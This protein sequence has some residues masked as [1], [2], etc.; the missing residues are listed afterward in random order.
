MK[1][2]TDI[3][4]IKALGIALLTVFTLASCNSILGEEDADCS[5]EYRVKFKYDYNMKY[6]DAFAHEVKSVTLYAFDEN[7]KFVY[8][9]TEQGDIL[10][11]EEYTMPV[12]VQPGDYHLI[13]WAGL[14]G[15]ESFAVPVLTQGVSTIDEL[16][17]RMNRT[18][19]RATNGSAVVKEDLKPLWHGEVTK[20]SFSSRAATQ[21]IVTVPLVK[22]T[23]NIRIVLQ[24]LSGDAVNSDKFDFNITDENGLMD[25]DNQLLEDETL[26]YYAW[27]KSDGVAEMDPKNS[28]RA[29][30]AVGVALAELTVGRLVTENKPILTITNKETGKKVLSIPLIDYLVLV[31]GNYNRNMSDQ[32]Y[33]DRQD[34]YSM[35]FFLDE[36]DRWV[37]SAIYIN[38]WRVVLQDVNDTL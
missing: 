5:I 20:H 35:T 9:R 23:N 11:E 8:Q 37:S 26:T 22:N 6:A 16:T 24:H 19:E 27:H 13:S 4:G 12:E 2:L 7:G 38:S 33:L 29:T 34:E 31:K 21:Q 28:S 15:E 14:E 1:V 30:T 10:A 3:K 32:E 17:C 25:Y 36:N 18:N